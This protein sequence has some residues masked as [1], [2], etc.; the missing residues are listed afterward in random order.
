MSVACV[1]YV[2]RQSEP[3]CF[4][5]YGDTEELPMQFAAYA[6]LDVI[7]ERLASEQQ[8]GAPGGPSGGDSYLGLAG[9]SLGTAQDASL[10]AYAAPTGLKIIVALTLRGA[11]QE[12]E[13]RAFF[14]RLHRLYADAVSNPFF[15]DT[16]ETPR[17]LSQ[18]DA[19]VQYYTDRLE[20]P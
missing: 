16:V 13:L 5:V 7:D 12:Q 19:I 18:L 9:P 8:P 4:R 2:G 3:L 10:F 20:T 14:K 6:A 17:F 1:C 11:L 15:L